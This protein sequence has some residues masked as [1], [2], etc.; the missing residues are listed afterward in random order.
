MVCYIALSVI[1]II[2]TTSSEIIY[3]VIQKINKKQ[4][5]LRFLLHVVS[6]LLISNVA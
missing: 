5:D 2:T 1:S 6:F 3:I 4:D